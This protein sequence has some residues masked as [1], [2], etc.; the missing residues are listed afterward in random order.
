[1]SEDRRKRERK[2]RFYGARRPF[3]LNFGRRKPSGELL[4]E[5]LAGKG[6]SI[7]DEDS[8]DGGLSEAK[9]REC[10]SGC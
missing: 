2:V 4:Q 8:L 9:V 6:R 10:G 5:A 1:M 7:P 3:R